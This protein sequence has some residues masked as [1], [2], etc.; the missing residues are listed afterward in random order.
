MCPV[1]ICMSSLK[2]YQNLLPV[3]VFAETREDS[4]PVNTPPLQQRF[5]MP[6][7]SSSQS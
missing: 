1:T 2:K 5:Q 3:W 6:E 4:F 7:A